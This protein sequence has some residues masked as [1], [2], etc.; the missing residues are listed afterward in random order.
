MFR[1]GE[2]DTLRQLD[3]D[4]GAKQF[5]DAASQALATYWQTQRTAIYTLLERVEQLGHRLAQTRLPLVLCHADIHTNNVLVDTAQQLWIVDWDETLL[6]P[7]ERDLMFV[8]GGI[9]AQLVGPREE[10]W[11]FEG[12]GAVALDQ[13]ALAYYRAAWA[14]GDI[15]AYGAQV[16]LRPDF[17][18]PTRQEGLRA[19]IGLFA[20][21]EIVTIAFGSPLFDL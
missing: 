18:E 8:A 5:A 11:F 1:F 17:G 9:S 12:Y 15:A 13:L 16:C 20:P 4:L 10:A 3:A 2:T 21:G 19:F 6:A 7:R 14:L